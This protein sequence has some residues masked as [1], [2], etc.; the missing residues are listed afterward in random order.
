METPNTDTP[1]PKPAEA[2][3]SIQVGGDTPPVIAPKGVETPVVE[4]TKPVEDKPAVDTKTPDNVDSIQ[5]LSHTCNPIEEY[6]K[7][8]TSGTDFDMEDVGK[9]GT[10]TDQLYEVR[11]NPLVV[12][13]AREI[14]EHILD[15]AEKITETQLKKNTK[16]NCSENVSGKTATLAFT[17]RGRGVYRLYL[18]NTGIF[19]DLRACKSSE[20]NTIFETIDM[21][22][23]RIGNIL[24]DFQY[25]PYDILFKEAIM[26][27]ISLIVVSTNLKNWDRGT[28]L[29]KSISINDYDAIV[30]ALSSMLTDRKLDVNVECLACGNNFPKV[31]D[32]G[33]FHLLREI[34]PSAL[35]YIHS[36]P[37]VV[38]KKALAEYQELLGFNNTTKDYCEKRIAYTVPSLFDVVENGKQILSEIESRVVDEPTYLNGKVINELLIRTN[39][40]F[41]PWIESIS[42]LDTNDDGDTTIAFRTEDTKEFA[43]I[44]DI[45]GLGEQHQ[46]LNKSITDFMMD[47]RA[48]VIGYSPTK[49]PKCGDVQYS[50]SGYVAW[51]PERIFFEI[52]YQT[53]ARE[54]ILTGE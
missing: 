41:V 2:P 11:D 5:H 28:T 20:L 14:Q 15:R 19:L 24:G 21:N 30:W 52:T 40:N 53:L 47:S 48:S 51:D 43:N 10:K 6:D 25:M 12:R 7:L 16:W 4:S 17:A 1:T 46:E 27:I 32:F 44:L 13:A 8:L 36:N 31:Y 45:D 26:E 3:A 49:C 38:D 23:E 34:T 9:K 18:Y 50:D 22:S 29:A 54:G 37:E 35:E 42:Q 39:N 33:R